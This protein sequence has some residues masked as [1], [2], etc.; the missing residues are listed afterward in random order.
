MNCPACGRNAHRHGTQPNKAQRWICPN[1]KCDV[2]TFNE[3]YGTIRYR[4]RI[5][6]K[7]LYEMVYLFFHGFPISDMVGLKGYS[8]TT[9]RST[10]S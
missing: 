8:E 2:V 6:D 4:M 3:R 10:F 7:D 1:N 5:E 9:I